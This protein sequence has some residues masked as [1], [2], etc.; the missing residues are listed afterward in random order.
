MEIPQHILDGDGAA[1][2]VY[3]ASLMCPE[4]QVTF[5]TDQRFTFGEIASLMSQNS[6]VGALVND[7]VDELME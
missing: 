5:G 7:R 4:V 2:A 6:G 3:L 1:K